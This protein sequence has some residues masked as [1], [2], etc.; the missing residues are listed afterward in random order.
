MGKL[1]RCISEDGTLTVMA[2]DSTD[3]VAGLS[4]ST[5]PPLSRRLH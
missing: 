5:K 4:V 3:I 2:L 1:V